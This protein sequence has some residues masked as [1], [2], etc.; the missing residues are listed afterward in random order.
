[1]PTVNVYYTKLKPDFDSVT[2]KIKEFLV[3]ELSGS[4]IKLTPREISVRFTRVAGDGMIGSIEI[5]I[6]A[7]AFEERIKKQDE[8]CRK[9]RDYLMKEYSNLGDIRIWLMLPQLGHSW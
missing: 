4:E 9:L 2:A 3:S 1:M 6:H 8:I 7:H 5:E